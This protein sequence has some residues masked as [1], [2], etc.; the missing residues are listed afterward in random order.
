MIA[1]CADVADVIA[2][3]NARDYRLLLAVHG[4]GHILRNSRDQQS[5]R[6][7]RNLEA[8]KGTSNCLKSP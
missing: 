1:R 8:Y 7:R 5:T 3:V 6:R 2:A 4:G